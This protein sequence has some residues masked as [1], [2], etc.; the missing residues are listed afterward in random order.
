MDIA[1]VVVFMLLGIFFFL[2]EI[3]LL[4]GITVSGLAGVAFV[5][6]SVW[7]AFEN[8]GMTAGWITL[9]GGLVAF[10]F[11]IWAFLK[12]KVI[13]RVSLTKEIDGVA[14]PLEHI[15]VS[16][17]DKGVTVTRMAPIGMVR[18]NGSDFEAK[19]DDGLL[20]RGTEVVVTEANAHQVIV[21]RAK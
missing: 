15:S 11:A 3:F 9:A 20:D 1:L 18:I 2:L 4:P 19:S 16:V 7:W 6:L 14:N 17:G 12:M 21:S 5:A 13:E 10:V 8:I